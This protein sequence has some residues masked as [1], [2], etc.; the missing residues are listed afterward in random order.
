MIEGE[1]IEEDERRSQPTRAPSAAT[2]SGTRLRRARRLQPPVV[3]E[4]DRRPDPHAPPPAVAVQPRA[5]GRGLRQPDHT[6]DHRRP[7]PRKKTR[8]RSDLRLVRAPRQDPDRHAYQLVICD[9]AHTALGERQRGD[10]SFPEPVFIG[11]TATEQLI[12][13]LGRLPRLGRRPAARR[14]R[15]A[16]AIAP[17]RC[18][19]VRRG[20][21]Q[22]GA[23]R[24]RRLRPGGPG[25]GAR[26]R[27]PQP[28]RR[29]PLPRPLDSTPASYAAGVEHAQ[30]RDG[31]PVGGAEGEAVSAPAGQARRVLAGYE[32]GG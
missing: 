27:R 2:A 32:R 23:D 12:M 15:T 9:E 16:R 8:S 1:A 13:A 28:G 24:R 30:P 20:R 26:P 22:L 31:V 4:H 17:L 5:E 21:D 14:R 18:L 6:G 11:M 19:R 3:S 7:P 10:R 29:Q 25:Q